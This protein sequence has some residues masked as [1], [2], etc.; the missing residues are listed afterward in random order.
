[1]LLVVLFA[2]FSLYGFAKGKTNLQSSIPT[3]A[4]MLKSLIYNNTRAT[5]TLDSTA[6][7]EL[8]QLSS[9]ISLQFVFFENDFLK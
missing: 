1:M 4:D 3:K 6:F 2:S 5:L 8:I 9:G 7:K